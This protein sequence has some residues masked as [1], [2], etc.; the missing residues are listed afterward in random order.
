MK[1]ALLLLL[2]ATAAGSIVLTDDV[3]Q[4]PPGEWR[5]VRFEI[6]QRPATV[7]CRLEAVGGGEVR[8]E[9]VNRTEL[10]RIHERKQHD[11]LASTD[12][13]RTGSLSQYIDQAGEY[14]VVVENAGEQ[15]A[16]VRL[17]VAL[18]FTAPPPV[19]R[20]LSPTRRL[21]VILVSF[22]MFFAIVT[23]SARALLRAMKQSN[24]A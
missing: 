15:P 16:A 8:A 13:A 7:E 14:A 4:I 22:A 2:A 12:P 20:S 3:F 21:T 9:L 6:R 19:S 5:W 18:D 24:G 17:N 11:A 23:V 1:F 10:E